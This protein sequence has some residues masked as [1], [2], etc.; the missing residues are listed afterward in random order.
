[1]LKE[2][3]IIASIVLPLV[4]MGEVLE[5]GRINYM[6]L[7]ALTGLER[8]HHVE[9]KY[10]IW[11]RL[12]S[13]VNVSTIQYLSNLIGTY[14]MSTTLKCGLN[15]LDQKAVGSFGSVVMDSEQN[16]NLTKSTMSFKNRR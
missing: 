13:P 16:L 10:L 2:M 15:S 12:L 4:C 14:T 7:E 11:Q 5:F 6:W 3:Y 9:C 8:G 1:M